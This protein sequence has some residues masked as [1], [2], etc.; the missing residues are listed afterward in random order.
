MDKKTKNPDKSNRIRTVLKSPY[1]LK[2]RVKSFI[3]LSSSFI[4]ILKGTKEQYWLFFHIVYKKRYEITSN[5]KL[6]D[7]RLS[8]KH[9]DVYWANW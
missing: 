8:S 4:R 7:L 1:L 2:K 6:D 5:L 3:I 9:K